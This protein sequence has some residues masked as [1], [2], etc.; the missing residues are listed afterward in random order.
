[1]NELIN[2]FAKS[3]CDEIKCRVWG[4]VKISIDDIK[5][6][7]AVDITNNTTG[8]KFSII[9]DDLFEQI[10]YGADSSDFADLIVGKYWKAVKNHTEHIYL[11]GIIE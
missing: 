7:C 6:T 2:V 3:L 10:Q 8:F 1:M 11:K 9:I 5:E 4:Y